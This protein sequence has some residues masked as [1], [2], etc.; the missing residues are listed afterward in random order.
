MR[1]TELKPGM[2]VSSDMTRKTFALVVAV[3]GHGDDD[4][5]LLLRSNGG[6]RLIPLRMGSLAPLLVRL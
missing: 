5:V 2:L 4:R 3:E 1:P 6:L